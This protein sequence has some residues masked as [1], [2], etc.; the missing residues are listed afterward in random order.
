MSYSYP[1]LSIVIDQQI[2]GC[3]VGTCVS[4]MLYP[5]GRRCQALYE[6]PAARKVALGHGIQ[7]QPQQLWKKN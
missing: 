7:L 4:L 3:D 5:A 1:N 2:T 6:H